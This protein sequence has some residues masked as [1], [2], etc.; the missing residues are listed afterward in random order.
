MEKRTS[1][2]KEASGEIEIEVV[3]IQVLH[4]LKACI[5]ACQLCIVVVI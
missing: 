2:E 1:D 3:S 4:V 5:A